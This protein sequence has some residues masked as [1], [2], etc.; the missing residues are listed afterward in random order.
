ME[1]ERIIE[2]TEDGSRTLYVPALNEH[3]HSTKGACTESRHIFVAMGLDHSDA[4]CPHILEVGFGTGLNA[5]LSM[6]RCT[7]L[8]RQ[9]HYTGVERYPLTWEEVEPLG[10][11]EHPLF[12]R[13]HE[14]PWETGVALTPCFTLHKMEADLTDSQT[15]SR[16]LAGGDERGDGGGYDVVYM[17]AFAPE[18]Q[19]EMWSEEMFRRLY[20]CLNPGGLLTTYC[21]KGCVRRLMQ[22]VGFRTERLPGPPGGKREMLRGRKG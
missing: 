2:Q 4:R 10:Y 5:L 19:P 12:R 3:Y 16:L 17:D 13:L 22:S 15:W 7:A 21:A 8:G 6:E 20:A 11:S 14:A 18:K 9:V 1:R